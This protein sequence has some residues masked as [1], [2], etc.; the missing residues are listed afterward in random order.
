MNNIK[1]IKVEFLNTPQHG[2]TEKIR[3]FF[4][5]I[6][7]NDVQIDLRP[8]DIVYSQTNNLSNSLKI[9][10]KKGVISIQEQSKPIYLK[11][12][13]GYKQEEIDNKDFLFELQNSLKKEPEQEVKEIE[14]LTPK[15][16]ELNT[17]I[18]TV[19]EKAI[20]D[21]EN[22]SEEES[23]QSNSEETEQKLPEEEEKKKKPRGKKGPGRPKKRGP[24]KGS[25]R[26]TIEE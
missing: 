16:T 18:D 10:S 15:N 25:K 7:S 12:Y 22:Y 20:K 21:V 26:K 4:K 23:L 9:Y 8:G 24:K 17:V 13:T 5:D 3:V 1:D 11:Y 14:D 2:Y 6:F 19:L